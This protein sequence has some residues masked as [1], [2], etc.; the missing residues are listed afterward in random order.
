MMALK[1]DDRR[2]R[3]AVLLEVWSIHVGNDDNLAYESPGVL[4][5]STTD[6]RV[7]WHAAG[8]EIYPEAM[9]RGTAELIR[10]F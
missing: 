8:P 5:D 1:F 10:R 2:L 9:D 6:S 7:T 3:D 4:N